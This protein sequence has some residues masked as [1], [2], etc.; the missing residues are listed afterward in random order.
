MES[1]IQSVIDAVL[2]MSGP[3]AYTVIGLLAY[4]EAAAFLGLVTPGET[5]MV[6][7]G[8]LAAEDQ[9]SLVTMAAVAAVAAA[10]GDSTGYWLGRRW[11]RQLA[12]WEPVRA[13]FGERIDRTA[14]Y[15]KD[16]GGSA[17][18][19]GRWATV[20]RTFL[21]FVAGLSRMPY[22]R[23]LLFSV[24]SAL[25]WAV[26]FVSLGYVAGRSWR[27]IQRYAGPA[28]LLVLLL[29]VVAFLIRV[30][31][32]R[33]M[34]EPQ[35]LRAFAERI[36]GTR[37]ARW[38]R[39]R[40]GAQL[41][42]LGR[43]FDPTIARGLNLTLGL[44]VVAA[45]AT[46]AGAVLNDVRGLEGL[47]AFDPPVRGWFEQVRTPTAAAVSEVVAGTFELPWLSAPT[48]L[49]AVYAWRRTSV[50]AALRVVVGAVGAAGIAIVART[51]VTE[52]IAATEFPSTA[53]AVVAALA[54]HLVA[55]AGTRLEWATA[56]KWVAAGV[57]AIVVVGVAEL[58]TADASLTGV[59]FGAAVGAAWAAAVEVQARLPFRALLDD[60]DSSG[61]PAQPRT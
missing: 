54:A 53:V 44:L 33:A 34:R 32:R 1:L 59:L 11:G 31:A 2:G 28:S 35:R 17:V 4:G 22:G 15:F 39:R 21:P 43:R 8:V 25:V 27:V 42:W 19:L 5:A 45:G 10:L 52:R 51:I 37:P 41:R 14:E 30:A 47:A 49:I 58:V 24:P 46:L 48:L 29:I 56:V 18:A 7:G 6:L 38:L 55:V 16:R 13:R 12:E 36:V 3:V 20:L 57:F 9:V 50:R 60:E 23:F 26:S 40:Y 61:R